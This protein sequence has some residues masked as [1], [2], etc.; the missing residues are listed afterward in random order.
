[1]H[2]KFLVTVIDIVVDNDIVGNDKYDPHLT[3]FPK[4]SSTYIE[5]PEKIIKPMIVSVCNR[6]I[7]V[8]FYIISCV[9][10]NTEF[11]G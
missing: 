11:D 10:S 7:S 8:S 3:S 4:P 6:S 1:M 9:F 5:D 2:S